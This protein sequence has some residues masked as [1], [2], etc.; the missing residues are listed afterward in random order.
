MPKELKSSI[1]SVVF[2]PDKWTTAEARKWLSR[3]KLKPIKIV[4][5]VYVDGKVT[6]LRYRI[7]DPKKFSSFTTKKLPIGINIV[8][9]WR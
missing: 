7:V 4:D 9:G 6:Q 3:H 2:K 5:K 1:H 8:L